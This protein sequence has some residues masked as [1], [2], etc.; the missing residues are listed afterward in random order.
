MPTPPPPR[1]PPGGT[2]MIPP[3]PFPAELTQTRSGLEQLE[4][5]RDRTIAMP[6]MLALMNMRL[7]EASKGRVVFA[8]TLEPRHTNPQGTIHGG[9]TATVP[10]SAM[11]C[12]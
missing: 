5:L 3:A 1:S 11:G 7:L 4:A 12:A 8:A 2:A 10:D 6:P 9:F